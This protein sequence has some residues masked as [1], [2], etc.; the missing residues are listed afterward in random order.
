MDNIKISTNSIYGKV[1]WEYLKRFM[2]CA[3]CK[4]F[5]E[6]LDIIETS[7]AALSK[8]I[9]HVEEALGIELFKRVKNNR[10][11]QLTHQGTIY[12]NVLKN[13]FIELENVNHKLKSSIKKT[14][15]LNLVTTPGL[16]EHFIPDLISQ[17]ALHCPDVA[18]NISAEVLAREIK[19]DEII[20]RSDIPE[21]KNIIKKLLFSHQFNLFASGEYIATYGSPEVLSELVHHRYLSLED[22]VYSG[23]NRGKIFL[24]SIGLK[25]HISSNSFNLLVDLC[26]KGLGIFEMPDILGEAKRLKKVFLDESSPRL[27]IHLCHKRA[28]SDEP[29]VFMFLNMA[30]EYFSKI[31]SNILH[32]EIK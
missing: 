22:R 25:P 19:E 27:D 1:N 17:Y 21:Q 29:H 30:K 5:K 24:V 13:S 6:A 15:E 32:G 26:L 28:L 11:T 23:M 10:T 18:I 12:F 7:S 9:D 8:Q 31:A 3:S 14:K 16:C 20:I 2:I 4:N